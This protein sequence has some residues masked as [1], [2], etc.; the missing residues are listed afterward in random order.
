MGPS[1]Q[2]YDKGGSRH[3][4]GGVHNISVYH[5]QTV[6]LEETLSQSLALL[7]M[8][9]CPQKYY[10]GGSRYGNRGVCNTNT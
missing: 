5:S 1:P 10:K 2:K 8:G 3:G 7:H 9:P 4:N 6:S